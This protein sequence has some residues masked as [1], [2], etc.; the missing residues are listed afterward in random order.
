VGGYHTREEKMGTNLKNNVS[1]VSVIGAGVSGL[2]FAKKAAQLGIN[3]TV[4]DQ[5]KKPGYPVKASGILSI[6]GLKS[7]GINYR[8]LK[9][10][11][12]YGARIHAENAVMTIKAAK[13]QAY[14]VNRLE[15][16]E[17][18]F[19]EA[20]SVGAD[21]NVGKRIEADELSKISKNS[22]IVGAD[23]F[24]SIV[25]RHFKFKG[26]Q[27]NILTYRA[28]YDFDVDDPSMVDL[29]FDN[30]ISPG[31]F[32]WISP[33]S[34]NV[35]EAGIGISSGNGNSREAYKKFLETSYAG[36]LKNKKPRAEFASVIPI[37]LKD[38]FVNNNAMLIGDA[39]GQV[40][41]I[42]GGGII[43]GATAAIMAAEASKNFFDGSGNLS[44]YERAWKKKFS[45][46]LLMHNIIRMIY[47]KIGSKTISNL[48]KIMNAI[49]MQGFLSKYGDMDQPTNIFKNAITGKS[50]KI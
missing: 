35:L 18:C 13:P 3:V 32:A 41:P 34:N 10:N 48:I 39:A 1:N 50:N 38:Y 44:D 45:T 26:R 33:E 24:N 5:N 19:D 12:L 11:P 22:I 2:I 14:A 43:L 6:N 15:L 31:F 7:T 17:L 23:G 8:K 4:Y 16:N 9:L 40:K 37:G 36:I 20:V 25:A 30:R 42:T 28:E 29:F 49:G 46:D 27:T 47:S 21:I